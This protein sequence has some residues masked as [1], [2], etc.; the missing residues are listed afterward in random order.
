MLL[1][2]LNIV[3]FASITICICR[4]YLHGHQSSNKILPQWKMKVFA[5]QSDVRR[6]TATLNE[7]TSLTK[8]VVPKL[9]LAMYPSA[10]R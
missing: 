2:Q 7:N 4:R 9:S 10:F 1:L 8:P 3:L 5:E 6:L